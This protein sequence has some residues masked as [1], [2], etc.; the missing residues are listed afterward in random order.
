MRM[1]VLLA[2]ALL[3]SGCATVQSG[4]GAICARQVEARTALELA[5]NQASVITDPGRRSAAMVAIRLS[6]A[7]LD[8]CPKVG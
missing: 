8:R 5:L 4:T 6:L 2:S 7:A 3:L 1:T